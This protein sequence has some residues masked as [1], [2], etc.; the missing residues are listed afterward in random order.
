[1]SSFNLYLQ[2][3]ISHITDIQG[4]DHILFLVTLCALYQFNQ[5]KKVLVLITAFTIGH[6]AT[7]L[8]SVFNLLI[9]SSSIIEFLIPLTILLTAYINLIK[10]NK[11]ISPTLQRL[12]YFTALFF[13]LIHGLGFSYYLKALL[14]TKTNIIKPLF[15]FNLGIELGQIIIVLSFFIISSIIIRVLKL[16]MRLWTIIISSISLIIS[17]IL[18]IIRFPV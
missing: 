8:L 12:K 14:G 9:I 13:G 2:L 4:Y 3:G 15:A 17:F 7:L 10:D 18:L 16:K 11:S 5:W 6:C 1:M